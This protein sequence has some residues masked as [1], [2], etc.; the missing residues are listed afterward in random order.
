MTSV[1]FV[2]PFGAPFATNIAV[3]LWEQQIL[4]RVFTSVALKPGNIFKRRGW[5]PE[6]IPRDSFPFYEFIRIGVEKTGLRNVLGLS[7]QSLVDWVYR[8]IDEKAARHLQ[9]VNVDGVYCYEDGARDTF[10]VATDREIKKIYD[11]PIPHFRTMKRVLEQEAD[12]HPELRSSIQ[13]L[14]EAHIKIERKEEEIELADKI[15]VAS[16][17][18]KNSLLENGVREAKIT[19][20]PYGFPEWRDDGDI[21]EIRDSTVNVLFVGRVGVRKGVHHLLEAWHELNTQNAHLTIIGIDEFPEHYLKRNLGTATYIPSLPHSEL[22]KFYGNADVFV[23]PSLIE[24]FGMVL[25]EAMSCGLPVITTTHT[26]GPDI[27]RDG[28]DGWILS[29]GN[30]EALT[31]RLAWCVDN[32]KILKDM[33]VSAKQRAGEYTWQRYRNDAVASILDT[34]SNA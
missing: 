15:I 19:V 2:H 27:I 17:F 3:A 1:T 13:S 22:K 16:Q 7:S 20:I 24:G 4:D 11:L 6:E 14:H 34:L 5:L 23:F 10:K 21:Q 25:L 29:P 32:Q 12:R 9:R 31:D 26:A 28:R 18:S 30:I 8:A 33:G